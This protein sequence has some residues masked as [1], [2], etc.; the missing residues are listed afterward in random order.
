M[1]KIFI[2]LSRAEEREVQTLIFELRTAVWSGAEAGQEYLPVR[3]P[4]SARIAEEAAKRFNQT[5]EFCR[6]WTPWAT[7]KFFLDSPL[8][9]ILSV[10]KNGHSSF[11]FYHP[12]V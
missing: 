4:S 5:C 7:I 1:K 9:I 3:A 12:V 11:V 10:D 2:H 6:I 8:S